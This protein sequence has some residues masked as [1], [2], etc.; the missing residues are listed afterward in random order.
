MSNMNI[1]RSAPPAHAPP[2]PP[3]SLPSAPAVNAPPPAHAAPA[4]PSGLGA[5]PAFAPPPL[6]ALADEGINIEA[7]INDVNLDDV[8]QNFRAIPMFGAHRLQAPAP[9]PDVAPLSDQDQHLLVTT[10]AQNAGAA[11]PLTSISGSLAGN[12]DRLETRL[13]S[14]LPGPLTH[15]VLTDIRHQVRDQVANADS[16]VLMQLATSTELELQYEALKTVM[17]IK[18][19]YAQDLQPIV[20]HYEQAQSTF[21]HKAQLHGELKSLQSEV[22][23]N[24]PTPEQKQV[25]QDRIVQIMGQL[26]FA[27][28]YRD[29]ANGP[30]L[31]MNTR[32]TA[33]ELPVNAMMQ[34]LSSKKQNMVTAMV[35]GMQQGLANSPNRV[36][37]EG[38]MALDQVPNY[39]G[40]SLGMADTVPLEI[41][42]SVHVQGE[43]YNFHSLLAEAGGG[44]VFNY[45]NAQGEQ[46][47]LKKDN[48]DLSGEI[49]SHFQAQGAN[50]VG[51]LGAVR[52]PHQEAFMVMEKADGDLEH[53]LAALR[54]NGT[55]DQRNTA[56][57]AL[58][59]DIIRGMK[60]VHAQ[61]LAHC[62]MKAGNV[63]LKDGIGKVADFGEVSAALETHSSYGTP[64]YNA[65]ETEDN[66]RRGDRQKN[67]VWLTGNVMYHMYTGNDLPF[68]TVDEK[69]AFGDDMNNRIFEHPQNAMERTI[70][71]MMHPDPAQRPSFE[72]LE[73]LSMF[74]AVRDGS[75]RAVVLQLLN[76]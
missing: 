29:T 65:P 21:E 34:Q 25:H 68:D 37:V 64:R 72:A 3:V 57:N 49:R 69:N 32:P 52:S 26:D 22:N 73:Q 56:L 46:V 47:V 24:N 67:D 31:D 60:D 40:N 50:S 62:D 41:P 66:T 33:P 2:A 55:Q 15:K 44:I 36:G 9:A 59:L 76:P 16:D 5:P 74:D 30:V 54:D 53:S 18:P 23:Y 39:S 19:K 35:R 12:L 6:P 20:Q 27:P 8:Q 14:A 7:L 17:Q 38:M 43:K 4:P 45:A 11:T 42:A 63:F 75:G 1:P 51:Y 61:G 13:S 58:S 28:V 48:E 10:Q 70:N 71:A